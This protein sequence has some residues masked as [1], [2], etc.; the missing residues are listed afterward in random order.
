MVHVERNPPESLRNGRSRGPSP[1]GHAGPSPDSSD[2][3]CKWTHRN[4]KCAFVL[5]SP[6]HIIDTHG[7]RTLISILFFRVIHVSISAT[8]NNKGSNKSTKA[9]NEYEG[10]LI[11]DTFNTFQRRIGWPSAL[12]WAFQNWSWAYT[13]QCCD[14]VVRIWVNVW[15]KQLKTYKGF[16]LFR[17]MCI[18]SAH[19]ARQIVATFDSTY[20][21]YENWYGIG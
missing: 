20:I 12:I 21:W 11:F 18:I 13:Y 9:K 15:M 8:K 19:N 5:I 17:Y 14:A 1:N 4:N 10:K 2:D 6:I 3:D 16:R 7:L